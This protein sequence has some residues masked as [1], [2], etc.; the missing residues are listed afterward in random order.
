[1]RPYANNFEHL[2]DELRWLD[3]LTARS[4]VACRYRIRHPLKRNWRARLTS[5][6]RRRNGR[7]DRWRQAR[8]MPRP[9]HLGKSNSSGR[10]SINADPTAGRV[11]VYPNFAGS[12]VRFERQATCLAP[13]LRRKYDRCTRAGR[14]NAQTSKRRLGAG[15][16]SR[17]RGAGPPARLSELAYPPCRVVRT[18]NDLGIHQVVAVWRSPAR[19]SHLRISD[20]YSQI[21]SAWRARSNSSG[22]PGNGC[23]SGCAGN[24]GWCFNLVEQQLN[25]RGRKLV[26][27]LYGPYG[28][29]KRELAMSVCG[30]LSCPIL[31]LDTELLLTQGADAECAACRISEGLPAGCDLPQARRCPPAEHGAATTAASRLPSSMRMKTVSSAV[32]PLGLDR[33]VPGLCFQP[34]K[35]PIPDIAAAGSG[36]GDMPRHPCAEQGGMG[37]AA[38]PHIPSDARTIHGG[39]TQAENRRMAGEARLSL[40]GLSAACRQQSDHK[41]SELA[42]K[43]EPLW[44][45]R[46]CA[47]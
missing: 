45:E 42:V 26:V 40:D 27:Y 37:A 4:A 14:H 2:E 23:T 30:R 7:T 41:L 31:T 1:M 15:S 20:G 19:S 25:D 28:V 16:S 9:R 24:F 38:R 5:R 18:L 8:A 47:A 29:G 11:P 22:R 6:L 44:L 33:I 10:E 46:Y 43:I 34:V 36:L 39:R 13:E 35:L 21:D 12:S 32:R 3:L 17:S